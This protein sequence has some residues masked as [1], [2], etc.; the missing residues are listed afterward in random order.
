MTRVFSLQIVSNRSST[1]TGDAVEALRRRASTVRRPKSVSVLGDKLR[2]S[3]YMG[4]GSCLSDFLSSR[5]L[6]VSRIDVVVLPMPK[7]PKR[8]QKVK[9]SPS[10]LH[11]Q[12]IR[13]STTLSIFFTN[14]SL[15]P[16]SFELASVCNCSACATIVLI[17]LL[18]FLQ[19]INLFANTSEDSLGLRSFIRL[20]SRSITL[21]TLFANS[22]SVFSF[23]FTLLNESPPTTSLATKGST[24][25]DLL[26]SSSITMM[27]CSC[28]AYTRWDSILLFR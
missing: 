17:L 21:N 1:S 3:K 27:G 11:A 16:T 8:A 15:C 28:L 2:K 24:A 7:L 10:A 23:P 26:T 20:S 9:P 13:L 19:L 22:C 25:T 12:V 4:R 5:S 18:N 14:A 6:R